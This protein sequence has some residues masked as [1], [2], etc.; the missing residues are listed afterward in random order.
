MQPPAV[1]VRLRR[2]AARGGA[3]RALQR[4]RAHVAQ[5]VGIGLDRRARTAASIRAPTSI[6]SPAAAGSRT[7]RC[8]PIARS[9]GRFDELQERNF[10]DAAAHSR[11]PAATARPRRE[12]SATTTP[13]H[14]RSRRSRRTALTPLEPNLK[15][16]RRAQNADDLPVLS[17]HLHD[18]RRATRSSAFGAEAGLQG[19][20]AGD[21]DRR[22]GRSRPARPRLLPQRRCEV[23]GTAA[24]STSSTSAR[25][26]RSLASGRDAGGGRRRDGA[27][28][29]TALAKA[30]LDASRAAIRRTSTT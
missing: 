7:I 26:S 19:R 15:R 4:P 8:R 16:H 18:D 21:R 25:C 29:E 2:V 6:S 3:G 22:S 24:S 14:G 10:D 20:D 27:A 5:T 13:L 12:R 11:A 1:R 28:I 30:S 17:P 9:W 23:G